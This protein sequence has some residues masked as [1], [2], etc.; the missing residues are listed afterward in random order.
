VRVRLADLLTGFPEL[1]DELLA[2]LL[3]V[4]QADAI[5]KAAA[6]RDSSVV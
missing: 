3:G 2:G 6:T 4:A 1:A 5:A